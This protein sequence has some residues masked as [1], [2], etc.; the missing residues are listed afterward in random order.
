MLGDLVGS[1]LGTSKSKDS[2]AEML[3]QAQNIP[4]PVLKEYYPEIYKQVAS[5][6][7]EKETAANLGP[8][9]MAGIST[10]PGLRQAQLNALNKLQDIGAAGGKDAQFM[11]D[12]N[13]IEN[14]INAQTQGQQGAIQQN[15][16]SRGMG[17]GMSEMVARNIS[18]QQG[19]NRM[20]QMGMDANAQAQQRALSALTQSGQLGGQ[21]QAQDFGQ[22]SQKAQAADA[23]SKFNA[24]NIQGVNQRNVGAANQA[25]EMNMS[26]AQRASDQNTGVK[27]QAQQYNL[28]LSQQ[29][30][31]NKMKK[32]GIVNQGLQGQGQSADKEQDRNNQFLGNVISGGMTAYGAGRK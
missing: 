25:Q 24:Q 13:R 10:D 15:M 4:L 3:K 17:G 22:Q 9:E 26:A 1:I 16:A 29:E 32:Q 19:S 30:F 7:P 27:N 12:Q 18:A 11:A 2:Y 8:S 21:M 14:D 23:I 31:D 28:G 20:A 5:M 6:N